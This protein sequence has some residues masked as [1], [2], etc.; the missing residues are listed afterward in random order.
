MR[1][2]IIRRGGIVEAPCLASEH[3]A[4]FIAQRGVRSIETSYSRQTG[5]IMIKS[6]VRLSRLGG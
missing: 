2:K 5:W 6:H 4:K 3:F 1:K